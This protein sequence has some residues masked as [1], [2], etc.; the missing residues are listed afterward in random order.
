MKH[1]QE[2]HHA[3]FSFDDINKIVSVYVQECVE[4]NVLK[5]HVDQVDEKMEIK[6][7][8]LDQRNCLKK[9][10]S[11]MFIR[12]WKNWTKR[13]IKVTLSRNRSLHVKVWR[14]LSKGYYLLRLIISLLRRIVTLNFV[15]Q[16]VRNTILFQRHHER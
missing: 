3:L 11:P 1:P 5:E 12:I 16:L 9:E 13:A 2:F 8:C 15:P 7:I 14:F 10:N 6:P 4:K